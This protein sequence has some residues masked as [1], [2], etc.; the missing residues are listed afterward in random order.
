[1]K[2]MSDRTFRV[3][4]NNWPVRD[5]AVNEKVLNG[6]DDERVARRVMFDAFKDKMKQQFP[7]KQEWP[8]HDDCKVVLVKADGGM[9][10]G[11]RERP[12]SKPGQP[13][14]WYIMETTA[15]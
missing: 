13:E 2:E 9:W 11:S 3:K 7:D 15:H 12:K 4:Y 8:D 6:L 1:M 10:E 14:D 5:V